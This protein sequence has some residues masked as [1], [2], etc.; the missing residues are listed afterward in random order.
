MGRNPHLDSDRNKEPKL[1]LI[2]ELCS[3]NSLIVLD[4]LQLKAVAVTSLQLMYAFENKK[5]LPNWI[6]SLKLAHYLNDLEPLSKRL[7]ISF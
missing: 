2:E 5:V 6:Y 1:P 3:E 7:S 4:C